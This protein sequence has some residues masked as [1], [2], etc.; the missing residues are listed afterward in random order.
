MTKDYWMGR[1]VQAGRD[2]Q[3]LVLTPV[4]WLTFLADLKAAGEFTPDEGRCYRDPPVTICGVQIRVVC[5]NC[6]KKEEAA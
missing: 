2:G 6:S 3:E 5:P 4:G 1:A